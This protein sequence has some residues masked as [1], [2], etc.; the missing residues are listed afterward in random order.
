VAAARAAPWRAHHRLNDGGD[1]E[2]IKGKWSPGDGLQAATR[3]PRSGSR[4]GVLTRG[5]GNST[6]AR[7]PTGRVEVVEEEVGE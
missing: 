1:L 7:V 3:Q 5:G 6:V 4:E 2:L